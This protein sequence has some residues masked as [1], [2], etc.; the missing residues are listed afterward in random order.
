MLNKTR[1]KEGSGAS[2]KKN[3]PANA[4]TQEMRV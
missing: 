2:G 4:E 1:F 3:L